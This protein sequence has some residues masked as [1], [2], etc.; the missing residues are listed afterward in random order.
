M[1]HLHSFNVSGHQNEVSVSLCISVSVTELM[2][3]VNSFW[4]DCM[5]HT[6]QA[7]FCCD[8]WT[9]IQLYCKTNSVAFILMHLFAAVLF[10]AFDLCLAAFANYSVTTRKLK[11]GEKYIQSLKQYIYTFSTYS[12]FCLMFSNVVKS[13][14]LTMLS[15]TLTS[16]CIFSVIQLSCGKSF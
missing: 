12:F 3:T 9:Q 6:V 7:S 14:V 15:S 10:T 5:T 8:R 4:F 2:K 1:L 11:T 13:N 16:F